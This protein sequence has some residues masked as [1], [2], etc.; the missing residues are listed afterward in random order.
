ML[1]LGVSGKPNS[2]TTL[3]TQEWVVWDR[4][5]LRIIC[6]CASWIGEVPNLPFTASIGSPLGFFFGGEE[7]PDVFVLFPFLFPKTSTT[8]AKDSVFK[9]SLSL[10]VVEIFLDVAEEGLFN[11][12][13]VLIADAS[14]S[15]LAHKSTLSC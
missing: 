15:L 12:C 8:D 4:L 5:I 14:S 2:S 13:E 11:V 9:D 6:P 3:T 10:S 7:Q 1:M